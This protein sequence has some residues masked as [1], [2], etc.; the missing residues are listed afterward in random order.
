MII[1]I[2]ITVIGFWILTSCASAP[3]VKDTD[4]S[5]FPENSDLY[6]QVNIPGFRKLGK[7]LG[8]KFYFQNHKIFSKG[9][10][11]TGQIALYLKGETIMIKATG[12]Y[13][14]SILINRLK[15]HTE[16][17]HKDMFQFN[18]P[19][20][21]PL[22]KTSLLLALYI[23]RSGLFYI[24]NNLE[25]EVEAMR[26]RNE[27]S[28]PWDIRKNLVISKKNAFFYFSNFS[29]FFK[30]RNVPIPLPVPIQGLLVTV[31]PKGGTYYFTG[32]IFFN[33]DQSD[34]LKL[35]VQ[36]R[37]ISSWLSNNQI[38]NNFSYV[39]EDSGIHFSFHIHHKELKKLML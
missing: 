23:P 6:L 18:T 35:T 10:N 14:K 37:F 5:F 24:S 20:L 19:V 34:R 4:L 2:F 22:M 33:E 12:N 13:P 32:I 30:N 31:D 8:K 9:L 3:K 25:R 16:I 38:I 26:N 28:L 7:L 17:L 39:Q 15:N 11:F 21:L 36:S 27:S 29:Q 1:S